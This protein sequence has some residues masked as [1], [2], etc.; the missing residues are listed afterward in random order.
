MLK[1]NRENK[2]LSSLSNPTLS[3][4]AITE[5][6][7]LQEFICNSPQVFFAEIGKELFLIKQEVEPS[8]KVKDRIDILALD[9]EGNA[10]II[11]LKRGSNKLQ[12][13]QAISYASMISHWQP[14]EFLDQL[15]NDNQEALIDFLEVDVE[16]INRQQNVV[17]VAEAFDYA[18]LVSAEW[19]SE[20]YGVNITCCRLVIQKDEATNN[21]YLSCSVIYPST[22]L[23]QEAVPRRI[24]GIN[25]TKNVQKWTD[26]D[27]ALIGINN[28]ALVSYFK[29][30]LGENHES[31]LRKR[32]VRYRF[33]GKRRLSVKANRDRGYVWQNGRFD[34][35]TD[36][37]KSRL[38][39]PDEVTTVKE[40]TCLRFFLETESDLSSFHE[41]S[42]NELQNVDWI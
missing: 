5:R 30:R 15:D 19:L 1:I 27:E 18:L 6:Y 29:K 33:E 24:I 3:E 13:L 38:S 26:W 34:G 10:V 36:F 17:L 39:L 31:Y 28:V 42:L 4:S 16:E 23:I 37:W 8:D 12:M 14:N 9:K 32:M 22:E 21:E 40:G 20:K 11:E 35:D 41:A 25:K 2:D 7:D